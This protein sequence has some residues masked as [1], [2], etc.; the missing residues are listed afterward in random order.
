LSI[1]V[2]ETGII[3]AS[4]VPDLTIIFLFAVLALI[5]SGKPESSH[6]VLIKE[7]IVSKLSLK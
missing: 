3:V 4:G 1:A 7:D 5:A 2:K 6:D